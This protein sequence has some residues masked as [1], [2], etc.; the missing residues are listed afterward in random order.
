MFKKTI[1]KKCHK[2]IDKSEWVCPYCGTVVDDS[3]DKT[4]IK[5]EK[6]I[7]EIFDPEKFLNI[8]INTF[9]KTNHTYKDKYKEIDN[10]KNNNVK[11]DILNRK[12]KNNDTDIKDWKKIFI[13]IVAIF[14]TICITVY[15]ACESNN[16]SYYSSSESYSKSEKNRE[17]S[18]KEIKKEFLDNYKTSKVKFFGVEGNAGFYDLNDFD[19]YT[20]D[21]YIYGDKSF[22][23]EIRKE[24]DIKSGDHSTYQVKNGD[25][26]KAVLIYDIDNKVI[27]T[28]DIKVKGLKEPS[29]E[30]NLNQEVE[31]KYKLL[32]YDGVIGFTVNTSS[33]P[34]I[35]EYEYPK[36]KNNQNFELYPNSEYLLDLRE[37]NKGI[38]AGTSNV[39]AKDLKSVTSINIDDKKAMED[40]IN[41][42]LENLSMD[43]KDIELDK[44]YCK[45]SYVNIGDRKVSLD[46][47]AILKINDTETY[48]CLNIYNLEVNVEDNKVIDNYYIINTTDI[49][50]SLPELLKAN[51][52]DFED[53]VEIPVK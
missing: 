46:F 2:L 13:I 43:I 7:N 20:K 25:V 24:K 39:V 38:L 6:R 30:V 47:K 31:D 44:L 34:A 5:K 26:V 14:A 10:I 12:E 50:T 53:M 27:A 1:C 21:K 17:F 16:D 18:K 15:E 52:K 4:F 42:N 11:I 45:C 49:Y 3:E 29:K 35:V 19:S 23:V 32:G 41:E 40:M 51:K 9:N 36:L 37:K 48:L 8:D 33:D 22:N 28:K